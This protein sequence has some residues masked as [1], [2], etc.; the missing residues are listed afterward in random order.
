MAKNKMF[1]VLYSGEKV[2][3]HS[4]EGKYYV[5]EGRR[6]RMSSPQIA[7]VE[8]GPMEAEKDTKK[9]KKPSEKKSD[10]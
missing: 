7:A 3:V 4:E 6:F 2:E 1:L 5:C 8:F 9:K 10:G